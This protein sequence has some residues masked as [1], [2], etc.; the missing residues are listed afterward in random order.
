M[1]MQVLIAGIETW[2][3]GVLIEGGS[4]DAKNFVIQRFLGVDLLPI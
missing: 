2:H 3:K 4:V 1:D